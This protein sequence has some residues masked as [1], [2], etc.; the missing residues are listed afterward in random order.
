M[1]RVKSLREEP[2]KYSSIKPLSKVK[3]VTS[4]LNM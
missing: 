3:I 2:P 4:R 1:R